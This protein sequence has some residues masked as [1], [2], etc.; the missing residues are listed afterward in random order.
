MNNAKKAKN[1]PVENFFCEGA[2][3]MKLGAN[4]SRGLGLHDAYV[5][6]KNR[7]LDIKLAGNLYEC[8]LTQHKFSEFPFA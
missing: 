6:S 8:D 5:K 4:E 3:G 2:R 1:A 7:R